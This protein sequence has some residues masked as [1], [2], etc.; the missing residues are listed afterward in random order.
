MDRLIIEQSPPLR[1]RVRISGSKNAALPILAASL[2]TAETCVLR[3]MPGLSDI[4][5]MKGILE[6]LGSETF[7]DN[8]NECMSVN[9]GKINEF[10]ADYGMMNRIRASFLIMGPM[11]ARFGKVRASLPGGCAI[12]SRPVDLH[13]K[14][15]AA[16]GA[17]ICLKRGCVEATAEKLRGT[18][19]HLDFPSVGATAN[20]V[21]A[22]VLTKGRTVIG[23]CA[24]EPEIGDL[25][26]FLNVLGA[27]INGIGSDTLV[28]NGVEGLRGGD[29]RII[30]DRI[31]AGTFM[32]AA[33]GRPGG[34][35]VLE[36][37]DTSHLRPV[38]AKL[39]EMG[40]IIN[41]EENGKKLTVSAQTRLNAS[42]IKTLPYPGFPTDMQ[43]QFM[44]L[45]SAS[46]GR[47]VMTETLFE[48][49]FMHAAEMSRMG[50]QVK[51]NSRVAIVDGV[52]RLAGCPVRATDLRAG[53][54]LV[55]AALGADGITEILDRFHLERG[56][57]RLVE[58]LR[59]LGAF[60]REG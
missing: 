11:L 47:G 20:I 17:D 19:I 50:A 32:A 56:Y 36:N 39:R 24:L 10:F 5:V 12:G 6:S 40:A 33:C 29:Y 27:D 52:E 59:G 48:N 34:N 41:E 15:L 18:E 16:L 30:P 4:L 54:A 1:G 13:L 53:A 25:C 31:E 23:N 46:T 44:A 37:V 55:V 58:K 51:I 21:M 22:A 43:A 60:V 14:G 57:F 8:E 45:L 42:D 7:Y 3:D 9:A 35:V 26:R 49:R 2:M 28:I 38:I